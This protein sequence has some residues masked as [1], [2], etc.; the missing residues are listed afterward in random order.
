MY[1]AGNRTTLRALVTLLLLT[2][3]V[4][5]GMVLAPR[6]AAQGGERGTIVLQTVSGGPIY[7]VKAD[8]THLRYL[9]NG[10]DPALSPDGHW[11]AFTRWDDTQHGAFGSLWLIKVDGSSERVVLNEV[12]QPK[13]PAWSPDGS[14]ITLSKQRGG[15][16]APEHKCSKELPSEPLIA[17]RDGDYFR[18]A[19]EVDDGDVEVRFC[20]TLLPHPNWGLRVVDV[21]TGEY[22]DLP[23][24]PFSY[25]PAWDPAND[26]RVIYDGEM[27]LVNLDLNRGATW[28][29]TEDV[30]D[31]GPVFSPDGSRIAVS[32]W[33]HDH[34]DIHR[35][36]ADGSG[37]VQLTKTPLRVI[38]DQK[39]NGGEGRAWNNVAPSWSPDGSQ[40][41]FLTDRTGQ[42]EV[43]VM[44]ADGSDQHPL[45]SDYVQA[46]LNLQ[47]NGVNE[48]MLSWVDD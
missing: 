23:G 7:A 17:D 6:A 27:G 36:M 21:A 8:G 30:H 19:V 22:E 40:I 37:R 10:M 42:W 13:S 26:W 29:L 47:Y 45:F 43:W 48:R 28:P 12:R 4:L 46:Q 35:M 2:L 1:I 41:A 5:G 3:L 25:A 11:V 18:V 20:Y 14:Q 34:W 9:T 24:D 16:L 44:R 33:Q 32:Y 38:V 15:R 31:H 39:V